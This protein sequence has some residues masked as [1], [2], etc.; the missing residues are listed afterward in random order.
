MTSW[1]PSSA[2]RVIKLRPISPLA[3]VMSATGLDMAAHTSSA[4][5]K[6]GEIFDAARAASVG[7]WRAVTRGASMALLRGGRRRLGDGRARREALLER[8]PEHRIGRGG[9]RGAA[10]HVHA[11]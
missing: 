7:P 10:H 3:P 1:R 8:A 5:R 2:R 6:W 11:E 4:R 9:Q